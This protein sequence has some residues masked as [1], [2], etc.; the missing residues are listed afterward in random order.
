M[1]YWGFDV[2]LSVYARC[3]KFSAKNL[4]KLR[5]GNNFKRIFTGCVSF[6]CIFY[7]SLWKIENLNNYEMIH[8]DFQSLND[9]SERFGKFVTKQLDPVI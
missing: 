8:T 7:L 1:H 6:F 9:V 2:C 3:L 4:N 5:C